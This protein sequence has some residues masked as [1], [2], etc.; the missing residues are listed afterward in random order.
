LAVV[1]L[2]VDVLPV[3]V[4]PVDVLPVDVLPVD[5]LPV[6]VLPVEKAPP[7][8]RSMQQLFIQSDYT[9]DS[10]MTFIRSIDCDYTVVHPIY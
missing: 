2:P 10:S 4:L 3:D 1:V 9:N 7:L 6:D 5:V 8:T